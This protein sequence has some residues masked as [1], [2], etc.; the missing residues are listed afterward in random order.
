MGPPFLG[1]LSDATSPPGHRTSGLAWLHRR[2]GM[3]AGGVAAALLLALALLNRERAPTWVAAAVPKQARSAQGS[4]QQSASLAGNAAADDFV[5]MGATHALV[6]GRQA[7]QQPAGGS[8]TGNGGSSEPKSSLSNS[9]S[10][11]GGGSGSSGSNHRRTSKAS[12]PADKGAGGNSANAAG[13][14]TAGDGAAS[15]AAESDASAAA[16]SAADNADG[17][18]SGD[19]DGGGGASSGTGAV[20]DKAAANALVARQPSA[21]HADSRKSDG[22]PAEAQQQAQQPQTEQSQQQADSKPGAADAD[23][24]Q[25]SKAVDREGAPMSAGSAK[26]P[27]QGK[28]RKKPR[29]AHDSF[30]PIQPELLAAVQAAANA[31]GAVMLAVGFLF[32]LPISLFIFNF[33]AI[34]H[35]DVCCLC[36]MVHVLVAAAF[37][38]QEAASAA[39]CMDGHC[40]HQLLCMCCVHG[41]TRSH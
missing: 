26:K 8:G 16:D 32:R 11:S 10:G 36:C 28:G 31:E 38:N 37:C 5:A 14:G 15:P 41:C 13:A 34:C 18:A 4:G 29:R 3:A 33:Q 1:I 30:G 39:D 23:A 2:R 9:P 25:G 6:E 12:G 27:R 20:G 22:G 35:L 21:G 40:G 19:S 17:A 24:E 7:L